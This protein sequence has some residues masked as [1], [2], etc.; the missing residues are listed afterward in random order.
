MTSHITL[1]E[2]KKLLIATPEVLGDQAEEIRQAV[3]DAEDELK[4]SGT[5]SPTTAER[6][7]DLYRPLK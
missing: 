1:S 3:E 5:L 6:L 4:S 7:D 2:L